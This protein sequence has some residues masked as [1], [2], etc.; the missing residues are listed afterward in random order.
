[1]SMK[2]VILAGGYGTRLS[3]ESAVRPKP[4][5]EIGGRPILWHIMKIYSAY[6][7]NEFVICCGYKG[8]MLKSYFA[9]YVFHS[10]D[11]TFD[12]A[13]NRMK[14]HG[15][16]AEPW[17]VTLVDT[18]EETMT[19]GRLKR[20][21]RWLGSTFCL[22]YG[23][24]VADIDI[25]ALIA[26]H[27]REGALATVTAVRQPGRFGAL[28]LQPGDT[29]VRSFREKSLQD[30]VL[31]NGGFFVLEPEALDYIDG[32]Q[33]VFEQEPLKRLAATGRLAAY[34]HPGFWQNMD[35]LRDKHVLEELWASGA[36]PCCIW[37]DPGSKVVPMPTLP[38]HVAGGQP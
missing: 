30:G 5:V 22:T 24:G 9:N 14:I 11:V 2:V 34:H 8:H 38:H 15:S 18:G 7:L 28:S 3:E 20:V 19:G 17:R 31:I 33:T 12:V 16:T 29:R 32:D 37:H 36:A 26:F 1:M 35:T 23:D 25:G 21:R 27:R 13:N 4:L 6:G 10:A